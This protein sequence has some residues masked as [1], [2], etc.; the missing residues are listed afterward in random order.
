MFLHCNLNIDTINLILE[1]RFNPSMFR[2]SIFP[3]NIFQIN[4][5]GDVHLCLSVAIWNAKGQLLKRY[6]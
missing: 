3:R 5:N 1:N 6:L 2:R 4:G